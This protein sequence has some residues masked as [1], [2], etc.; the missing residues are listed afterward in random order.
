M[1]HIELA[2][3]VVKSSGA[4]YIAG[5]ANARRIGRKVTHVVDDARWPSGTTEL[6]RSIAVVMRDSRDQGDE[7]ADAMW[8]FVRR[9]AYATALVPGAHIVSRRQKVGMSQVVLAL[10]ARVAVSALREIEKGRSSPKLDTY[11]RLLQAL[12]RAEGGYP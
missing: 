2:G 8:A 5:K 3:R 4:G 7:L 1:S 12:E 10:R 6:A 9:A 11:T